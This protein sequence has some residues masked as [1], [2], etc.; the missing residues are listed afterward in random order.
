[1]LAL[2][3]FA[4]AFAIR[5][6]RGAHDRLAAGHAGSERLAERAPCIWR[7]AGVNAFALA[8]GARQLFAASVALAS[9][10]ALT[11]L[12]RPARRLARLAAAAR[13]KSARAA[14]TTARW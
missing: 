10:L 8:G 3:Q 7:L 4:A 12:A 5:T 6:I 9:T 11:G 2:M 14:P 1:M 13:P